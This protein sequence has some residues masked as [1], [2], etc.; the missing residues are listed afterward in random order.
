[1]RGPLTSPATGATPASGGG[2]DTQ[3]IIALVEAQTAYTLAVASNGD[4]LNSILH[5]GVAMLQPTRDYT[6]SGSTLTLINAPS[7]ADVATGEDLVL[8]YRAA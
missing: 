7:A 2:Y 6:L 3:E 5:W 4:E 1:M 8:R